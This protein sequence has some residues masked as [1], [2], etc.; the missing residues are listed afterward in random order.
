MHCIIATYLVCVGNHNLKK[1]QLNARKRL[2]K[3]NVTSRVVGAS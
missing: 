3:L 1:E 2:I